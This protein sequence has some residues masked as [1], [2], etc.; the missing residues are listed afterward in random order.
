ME[1][2][3]YEKAIDRET[4][5]RERSRLSAEL[6]LAEV[7]RESTKFKQRSFA[8]AIDFWQYLSLNATRLWQ[9]TPTELIPMFLETIFPEGL[10]VRRAIHFK[11]HKHLSF[12][13]FGSR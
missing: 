6:A 9:R 4:H 2:Y 7:D 1:A 5:D 10:L 11:P 13:W 8:R 3:V 12:Q